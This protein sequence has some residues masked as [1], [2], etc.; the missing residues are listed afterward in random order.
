MLLQGIGIVFLCFRKNPLFYR[1]YVKMYALVNEEQSFVT[2]SNKFAH[3][4]HV[5]TYVVQ[6]QHKMYEIWNVIV[7]IRKH[8]FQCNDIKNLQQE[9]IFDLHTS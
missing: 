8:W 7:R 4:S 9:D 1:I 2:M 3:E 6:I 5:S